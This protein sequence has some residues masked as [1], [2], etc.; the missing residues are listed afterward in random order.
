MFYTFN[1]LFVCFLFLLY[2]HVLVLLFYLFFIF[3]K[4]TKHISF[5]DLHNDFHTFSLSW[6]SKFD[7]LKPSLYI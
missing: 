1:F 3:F 6:V 7:S 2:L 4:E 5:P